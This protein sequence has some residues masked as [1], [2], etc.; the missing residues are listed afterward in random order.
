M[1]T[2]FDAPPGVATA[3]GISV[4]LNNMSLFEYDQW[5]LDELTHLNTRYPKLM[6]NY[7]FDRVLYWKLTLCHNVVINSFV[8]IVKNHVSLLNKNY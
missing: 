3:S 5:V 4:V 8:T 1:F 2:S 7:V 6:Y